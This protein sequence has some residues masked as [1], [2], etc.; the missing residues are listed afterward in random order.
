M[1]PRRMM[2]WIPSWRGCA[3]YHA[4][5]TAAVRTDAPARAPMRR[6]ASSNV[7]HSKI[8]SYLVGTLQRSAMAWDSRSRANRREIPTIISIRSRH[9]DEE[10][11]PFDRKRSRC[12]NPD[13]VQRDRIARSMEAVGR[14]SACVLFA[15]DLHF[16]MS[17]EC[18]GKIYVSR[19]RSA[20]VTREI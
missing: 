4:Y 16:K 14:K 6:D 7:T 3:L 12:S 17:V 15:R 18:Y 1:L 5:T 13:C 8:K 11:F 19:N 2:K 20:H 9:K 10:H